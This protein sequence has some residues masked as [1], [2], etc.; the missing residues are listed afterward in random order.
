MNSL[1]DLSSRELRR[2]AAIKD[3]IAKLETELARLL[4]SRVEAT[5][6]RGSRPQKPAR[7]RRPRRRMSA[8]A[9]AK[10]AA[11]ARARWKKVKAAGKSTL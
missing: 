6:G 3:R 7:R 5:I 10:L 4:R 1:T 8:A 9:R 2:A 11:A